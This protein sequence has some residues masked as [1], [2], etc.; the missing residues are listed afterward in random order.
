VVKQLCGLDLG[1]AFNVGIAVSGLTSAL[2][3]AGWQSDF[4]HYRLIRPDSRPGPD[5][6]RIFRFCPDRATVSPH[7]AQVMCR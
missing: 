4:T 1:F 7:P 2:V 3:M 6:Y 5:T